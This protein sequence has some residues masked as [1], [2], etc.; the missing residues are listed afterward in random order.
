MASNKGSVGIVR[1]LDEL[2]RVTIPIELR[3]ALG[4]ENRDEL[5]IFAD[6]DKVII[7]KYEP[8]DIFTGETEDL[9]EYCGKLVS[10]KSIIEMAKLAGI[11]DENADVK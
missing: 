10:R 5:E 2:G 8:S 3:R 6:R 9:I 1:R 11:I 7:K 4:A